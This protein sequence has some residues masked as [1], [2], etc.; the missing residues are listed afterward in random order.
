[1][2]AQIAVPADYDLPTIAAA[3]GNSDVAAR[4]YAGGV[5]HVDGVTQQ[6]L[7]DALA[8][9]D[10]S[11]RIA[12]ELENSLIGVLNA[13]LDAVA[14]QRRYDNRFTCA[15][16]AGFPGPFQAEGIAFA[17]FMDE[18]NMAGYSLMRSVKAGLAPVPTEAELIA[19]MPVIE[20]PPSPIPV[21]A[22]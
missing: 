13:H 7:D 18:C 3:A 1:V 11:A 9:Y 15:L 22:A 20:W 2:V 8:G 12:V 10:H 21:G 5:L 6:Q 14:G 4:R 17:Q 19:L 16:R